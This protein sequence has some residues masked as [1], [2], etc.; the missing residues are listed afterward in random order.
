MYDYALGGL[1]TEGINRHVIEG[2]ALLKFIAL[3]CVCTAGCESS[4][5]GIAAGKADVRRYDKNCTY[6]RKI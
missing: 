2:F 4:Y 3:L 1:H 6:A 5:G